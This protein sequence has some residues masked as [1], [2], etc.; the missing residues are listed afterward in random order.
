MHIKRGHPYPLGATYDGKG[1]N[2]AL[3]SEHAEGVELCL[4]DKDLNETKIPLRNRTAFVWHI[5]IDDIKPGQFYAYR[6]HG[7]YRPELGLRFNPRVLLMDPYAKALSGKEN[8]E[9]G[10][11]AYNNF[12]PNKDFFFFSFTHKIS[13][14]NL[15][16]SHT[17][18]YPEKP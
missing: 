1:V 18:T 9:E 8:P 12:S 4:F 6:V 10:L 15:S 11:F 13:P 16:F 5:Y 14:Q 3:Y 7:Q 17:Q 2:F